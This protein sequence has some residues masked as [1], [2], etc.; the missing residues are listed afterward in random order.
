MV[1]KAV[2]DVNHSESVDD[3][4]SKVRESRASG[5]EVGKGG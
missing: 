2:S 4:C 5:G 1:P 3:N